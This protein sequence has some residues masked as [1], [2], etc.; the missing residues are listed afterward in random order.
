[1]E[2]NFTFDEPHK[3][4][5]V[6]HEY[7]SPL[8]KATSIPTE[9]IELISHVMERIAKEYSTVVD[10]RKAEQYLVTE[11]KMNT[12][13]EKLAA[14]LASYFKDRPLVRDNANA[15]KRYILGKN[16]GAE[17]VKKFFS[18]M[19]KC[20]NSNP[21]GKLIHQIS[22]SRHLLKNLLEECFKDKRPGVDY[23]LSHDKNL[24]PNLEIAIP[25]R[26]NNSPQE[27]SRIADPYE[28]MIKTIATYLHRGLS[29]NQVQ[30][31]ILDK[32]RSAQREANTKS[33]SVENTSTDQ[34]FKKF[35]GKSLFAI[36]PRNEKDI[37]EVRKKINRNGSIIVQFLADSVFPHVKQ[38]QEQ[39]TTTAQDLGALP[40]VGQGYSGTLENRETFSQPF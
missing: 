17:E 37:A 18:D 10:L 16:D 4:F 19:E 40:K 39:I 24:N 8:G 33:T 26:A 6:T 38:F 9:E 22:L 23:G 13:K 28:M 5:L 21:E 14:D 34:S 32:Q 11:E 15:F 3:H 1:M 30:A 25:Y 2:G 31:W 20:M 35:F 12:L 7:N 29:S 36:D 27:R